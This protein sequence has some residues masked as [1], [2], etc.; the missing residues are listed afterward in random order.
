MRPPAFF[1]AAGGVVLAAA[2]FGVSTLAGVGTGA[3]LAGSALGG[4]TG[5][6]G[7]GVATAAFAALAF[8]MLAMRTVKARF[9]SGTALVTWTTSFANIPLPGNAATS[10]LA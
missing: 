7:V 5:A 2:A 9:A 1:F 6:A 10:W 3:A 8:L 4:A